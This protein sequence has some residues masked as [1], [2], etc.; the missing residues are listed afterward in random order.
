MKISVFWFIVGFFDNS[1]GRG[2]LKETR[3]KK[4]WFLKAASSLVFFFVLVPS[5]GVSNSEAPSSKLEALSNPSECFKGLGIPL[6]GLSHPPHLR[7]LAKRILQTG[8]RGEGGIVADWQRTPEGLLVPSALIFRHPTLKDQ[9]M[10]VAPPPEFI[11]KL[12]DLLYKHP[13]KLL[14]LTQSELTLL[15]QEIT[16]LV[17]YLTSKEQELLHL[18]PG[19]LTLGLPLD[20]S[21]WD[22]P[23]VQAWLNDAY[24]RSD[25]EHPDQPG[26]LQ[27]VRDYLDAKREI[28]FLTSLM[29]DIIPKEHEVLRA[30]VERFDFQENFTLQATH[31][32][33]M[34][35]SWSRLAEVPE[36]LIPRDPRPAGLAQYVDDPDPGIRSIAGRWIQTL[37]DIREGAVEMTSRLLH[38]DPENP[39]ISKEQLQSMLTPLEGALA[40]PGTLDQTLSAVREALQQVPDLEFRYRLFEGMDSAFGGPPKSES[41]LKTAM[42]AIFKRAS[43]DRISSLKAEDKKA[44]QKWLDQVLGEAHFET[45]LNHIRQLSK[46][47][48]TRE[49]P[50]DLTVP[51]EFTHL[52][53]LRARHKKNGPKHSPFIPFIVSLYKWLFVEKLKTL[54]EAA[55]VTLEVQGRRSDLNRQTVGELVRW[56]DQHK[57]R[58]MGNLGRRVAIQMNPS[59][60]DTRIKVG[61]EPGNLLD[62]VLPETWRAKFFSHYSSP[63]VSSFSLSDTEK[64][65]LMLENILRKPVDFYKQVSHL[66]TQRVDDAS[67]TADVSTPAT[68]QTSQ[69][70]AVIALFGQFTDWLGQINNAKNK[71]LKREQVQIHDSTVRAYT[72]EEFGAEFPFAGKPHLRSLLGIRAPDFERWIQGLPNDPIELVRKVVFDPKGLEGA[73]AVFKAMAM[74]EETVR[75]AQSHPSEPVI[76]VHLLKQSIEFREALMN[77]QNPVGSAVHS[78]V[79]AK[80]SDLARSLQSLY[81]RYDEYTAQTRIMPRSGTDGLPDHLRAPALVA[82][83]RTIRRFLDPSLHIPD[84]IRILLPMWPGMGTRRSSPETLLSIIREAPTWFRD[85][86]ENPVVMAVGMSNPKHIGGPANIESL[87]D[88]IAQVMEELQF[89]RQIAPK[90]TRIIPVGRSASGSLVLEMALRWQELSQRYGPFADAF[91]HYATVLPPKYGALPV[92]E[93]RLE[94]GRS[95]SDYLER[96]SP[97]ERSRYLFEDPD[98]GRWMMDQLGHNMIYG[99]KLDPSY[100]ARVIPAA[101][102]FAD[103]VIGQQKGMDAALR[104]PQQV[105][106]T[107]PMLALYGRKDHEYFPMMDAIFEAYLKLFSRAAW[108]WQKGHIGMFDEG[109]HQIFVQATGTGDPKTSQYEPN[110]AYPI[111]MQIL[112]LFLLDPEAF[113][114]DLLNRT[115]INGKNVDPRHIPSDLRLNLKP[116]LER[117]G[118]HQ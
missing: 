46:S 34:L 16:N 78:V 54:Q 103:L 71:L 68:A 65:I 116:H 108:H 105:K 10:A 64:Q 89:L 67:A 14:E 26:R 90:E 31:M 73:M 118:W 39:R 37:R 49:K 55:E 12:N 22:Q 8:Q 29:K 114:W 60:L 102:K 52:R 77:Q 94:N 42:K 41:D 104:N 83:S 59:E 66:L 50:G 17:R 25:T 11:G 30:Y 92:D 7:T 4:S 28:E 58:T 93:V 23:R 61:L 100:M 107:P 86:H 47:D 98:T 96:L 97:E 38:Q 36:N 5:P 72:P 62:E 18:L 13:P 3:Q 91:V 76:P 75:S 45:L 115:L 110:R 112:Q 2:C 32:T 19:E 111:A 69:A 113:S 27:I 33:Q 84:N 82:V 53:N 44:V 109:I 95:L 20:V 9:V 6:Q 63:S 15:D 43:D 40:T 99:E 88:W 85:K 57:D 51:L 79:M 56:V 106:G 80:L 21:L 101:M 35:G 81:G 87:D 70:R 117:R 1:A 24:A 48:E 74:P